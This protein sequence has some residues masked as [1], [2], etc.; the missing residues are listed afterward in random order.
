MALVSTAA[1]RAGNGLGGKTH[2]A[3][4]ATATITVAAACTA[5]A[6][7]G[8]TIAGVEGTGDVRPVALIVENSFTSISAMVRRS[9][10]L[11]LHHSFVTFTKSNRCSGQVDAKF[12]FLNIPFFKVPT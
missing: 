1:V 6:E 10:V 7:E 11:V 3:S 4:V 9:L 5:L 12:S 2:I 8:F